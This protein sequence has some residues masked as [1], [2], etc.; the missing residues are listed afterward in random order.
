MPREVTKL[1]S[2]TRV[3]VVIFL[4]SNGRVVSLLFATKRFVMLLKL[5][6]TGSSEPST[7]WNRP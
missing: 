1:C 5:P 6:T 4:R 7:S 3:R 2:V